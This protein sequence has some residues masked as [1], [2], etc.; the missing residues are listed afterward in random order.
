MADAN[1]RAT[2]ERLKALGLYNG[3]IDGVMGR[4]TQA[5][6][7]AEQAAAARQSQ[8]ETERARIEASS[9]QSRAKVEQEKIAL[10]RARLEA[11]ER[12]RKDAPGQKITEAL[13][14]V[15][16]LL[17]GAALGHH[18]GE[19]RAR[20]FEK[21]LER[22][23]RDATNLQKTAESLLNARRNSKAYESAPY[24]MKGLAESAETIERLPKTGRI[25]ALLA[26]SPFLAEGAYGRYQGMTNPDPDVAHAWDMAGNFGLAAGLG[27]Y[28]T[29]VGSR[30]F[31]MPPSPTALG[32]A[33]GAAKA[34][35]A[36]LNAATAAA[37]KSS[38]VKALMGKGGALAAG[39]GAGMFAGQPAA[40]AAGASDATAEAVGAGAGLAGATAISL[41][42]ARQI[43]ARVLGPVGL[44]LTAYDAYR[45]ADQVIRN[46]I[47]NPTD[48]ATKYEQMN[49]SP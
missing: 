45:I 31:A 14:G 27:Q 48:E 40:K 37:P 36:Q 3:A 17:T 32:V 12:A 4:G 30:H 16:P 22:G 10:E 19:K 7:A 46:E 21:V 29:E 6:L 34:G 44:A 1:V 41:P 43:A 2:Q 39:F 9:A 24:I 35:E 20:R 25:G 38:V 8:A 47:A 15:G 11:D 28:G 5:A 26:A 18:L 49:V 33:K 13:M 42:A 23:S